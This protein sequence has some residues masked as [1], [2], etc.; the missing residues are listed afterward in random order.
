MSLD[1]V[2]QVNVLRQ[3]LKAKGMQDHEIELDISKRMDN[4]A[5]A[6]IPQAERNKIAEDDFAWPEERKYPIVTQENL[7]AA[8]T[9][10]GRAPSYEQENIK[11]NIKRIAQRRGLSL[12]DKWTNE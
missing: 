4:S 8:V 11:R 12:P 3:Q 5:T 9:L 1:S 2:E 10:L 7:D 6:Y